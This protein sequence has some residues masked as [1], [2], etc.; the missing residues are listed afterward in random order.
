MP[1]F[2]YSAQPGTIAGNVHRVQDRPTA[3]ICL[4]LLLVA[5]W[6]LT[7]RYK[8]LGGDAELYAMQA[9]AKIHHN[10]AGDLFLQNDSQDRYTVFSSLYALCIRWLGLRGA[11]MTLVI[12][13]K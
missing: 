7:H 8:G 2:S 9:L 6:P 1:D 4:V 10:L 11:A 3:S 13:F 5:L 12:A